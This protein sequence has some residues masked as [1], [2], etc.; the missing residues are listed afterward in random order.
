ME[1]YLR[2]L[3]S[4]TYMIC[5]IWL[6]LRELMQEGPPQKVGEHHW[7]QGDNLLR[8]K[9]DKGFRKRDSIE[10]KLD[11]VLLLRYMIINCSI[12]EAVLND[13]LRFTGLLCILC[14]PRYQSPNLLRI[15]RHVE[16]NPDYINRIPARRR[17][18]D[19]SFLIN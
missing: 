7:Q 19:T 5:F 3:I 12:I 1:M 18:Y 6:P 2:Y 17:R 14:V 15:S 9:A 11:V 4:M 8:S 10:D 16:S 13:I